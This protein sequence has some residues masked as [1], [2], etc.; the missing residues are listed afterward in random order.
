[1]AATAAFASCAESMRGNIDAV[2]AEIEDPMDALPRRRF[3]PHNGERAAGGQSLNLGQRIA[4]VAGAVFEI[5]EPPVIA[6][7]SHQF[8]GRRR[9]ERKKQPSA[10]SPCASCSRNRAAASW[11]GGAFGSLVISCFLPW[12][13]GVQ[14][15]SNPPKSAMVRATLIYGRGRERK[16]PCCRFCGWADFVVADFCLRRRCLSASMR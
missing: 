7:V 11:G 3:H 1:M 10:A 6:G 5:D 13:L 9:S 4:L 14:T 12:P 2:G 16:S 8:G 15:L